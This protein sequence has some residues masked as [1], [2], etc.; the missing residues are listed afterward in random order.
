MPAIHSN[1]IQRVLYQF[2][3]TRSRNW[4]SCNTLRKRKLLLT[5]P[6]F[7]QPSWTNFTLIT[8]AIL[9]YSASCVISW[10]HNTHL[11]L[12]ME[13]F[14]QFG[15]ML[16]TMNST[17]SFCSNK[18]YN[19]WDILNKRTTVIWTSQL[20]ISAL[21]DIRP[22]SCWINHYNH[23]CRFNSLNMTNTVQKLTNLNPDFKLR[24]KTLILWWCKIVKTELLWFNFPE[25]FESTIWNEGK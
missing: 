20:Q 15:H 16:H 24:V 4:E 7:E 23:F 3:V 1:F 21:R 11:E 25:N 18:T 12:G 17:T 19:M 13:N 5:L 6:D 10:S 14:V 9:V 2:E 22:M 8:L